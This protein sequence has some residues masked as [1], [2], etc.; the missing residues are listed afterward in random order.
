MKGIINAVEKENAKLL[1]VIEEQNK[2]IKKTNPERYYQR[3]RGID[4]DDRT[5][6]DRIQT[7]IN[8][9]CERNKEKT[10]TIEKLDKEIGEIVDA[11]E[12][13]NRK[14]Q[15]LNEK[16]EKIDDDSQV[17]SEETNRDKYKYVENSINRGWIHAL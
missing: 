8:H 6:L 17:S 14:D 5:R 11:V 10:E 2:K 13:L 15:V 7:Q 12:D 9:L 4:R 16:I 1:K 3:E